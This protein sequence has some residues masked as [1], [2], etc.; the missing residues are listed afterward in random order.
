MHLIDAAG[1]LDHQ[2]TDGNPVT[3]VLATVVDAAWL[4]SV[5][6]ELANVVQG[7]G[8]A[9]DPE[10]DAQLLAAIATL[11]GGP[12]QALPDLY[13]PDDQAQAENDRQRGAILFPAA[14]DSW[15]WNF[16][17]LWRSGV[18]WRF[19]L[20]L[21]AGAADVSAIDLR[22]AY[23]LVPD[24]AANPVAKTR[25]AN[26][27]AYALGALVIPRGP[28]LN[29]YY[30]ECTTA[31]TSAAAPPT[32]GT[33]PGGTTNDGGVVW[34]CRA[35]GFKPLT[36]SLVPPGTAYQRYTHYDPALV[37]PAAEASAGDRLHVG[38][39]RQGTVDTNT[40]GM[41]LTRTRVVPVEVA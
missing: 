33:T 25:R 12:G 9:L 5:Q 35:G 10:D 30:Y 32:W 8:L 36:S 20:D 23:L 24:G 29:G 1:H 16:I 37:I 40:G 38:I 34:T 26:S 17:D 4:N 21:L 31:G 18:D 2:F 39:W 27:T 15:T 11:T 22:L 28:S 7:A 3:G 13:L 41:L 6:N 19:S 14:V